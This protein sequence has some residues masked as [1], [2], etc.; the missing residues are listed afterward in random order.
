MS[1]ETDAVGSPERL[2]AV[3]MFS[4]QGSQ[5]HQMGREL[6][7]ADAVFR[8]ALIRH[9]AVVA[10][11]SGESVLERVFDP[12]KRKS[13]PFVDTRFTHPAIVM[14][15]LALAEAVQAAGVRPRYVLGAS[16][17]EYAAAAVAGAVEPAQCLRLVVRQAALLRDEVPGGMLAVLAD[18]TVFD[19]V[20]VLHG[21][22]VAA[23]NYPGHLVVAGTTDV[24]DRAAAQLRAAGVPHQRVPVEHGFHSYLM[25]DVRERFADCFEGVALTTPR[26]PWVSCVDGRLVERP[27]A[28]HFWRVARR[29]IEFGDTMGAMQA[30]GDFLYVDLGPSGTL[31]GFAA[32]NLARGSRS[33]SMALLSPFGQDPDA[34]A[35]IRAAAGGTA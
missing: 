3:F 18:T 15:Q 32:N 19:D 5:Y 17:G 22:D 14:F 35:R 26:V 10:E 7:E 4:G 31:H 12:A 8:A 2:P 28:G 20:P 24:L 1:P 9:D 33:R 27:S 34:P 21:T 29:P 30:R 11:E 16:L 13:D 6:F 25:D 23:R